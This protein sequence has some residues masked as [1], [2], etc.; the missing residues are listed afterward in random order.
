MN[1]FTLPALQQIFGVPVGLSDH[2]LGLA[3]PVAAITLGASIVEKHL[4][5][6]RSVPGPDSAFSLEPAEFRQMV[7]AIRETEKA[8]GQVFFG[9]S[10]QENSS[11]NF[12]RS[13][14]VVEDM[15]AGEVFT[16]RNV[17]SIRPGHGLAPRYFEQILGC[18]ACCEIQ[19]GT[20][21]SWSLVAEAKSRTA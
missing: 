12:R 10:Q 17:R 9:A 11:R 2:T 4:T 19:R 3:A 1:L 14:F 18:P 8:L 5:L 6:S 16:R 20:P 7:N 21:L 15:N 13:L